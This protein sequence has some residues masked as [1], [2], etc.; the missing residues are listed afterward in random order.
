MRFHQA[1]RL[2]ILTSLIAF[3]AVSIAVVLGM[4]FQRAQR[5]FERRVQEE[6]R[7]GDVAERSR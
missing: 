3:T 4:R 5:A 6:G 1:Q 7:C 2:L